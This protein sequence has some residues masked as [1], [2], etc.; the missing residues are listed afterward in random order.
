MK[1]S[2]PFIGV[3]LL[4]LSC[5]AYAQAQTETVSPKVVR[6]TQGAQGCD[7]VYK[8]GVGFYVLKHDGIIIYLTMQGEGKYLSPFLQVFNGSMKRFTVDPQSF[9]LYVPKTHPEL[10]ASLD[11]YTVAKSVG[12]RGRLR[13]ALAAGL[14]GAAT[15][16]ST[17]T[18][19]DNQGNRATVTATEPDTDAQERTRQAVQD[20]AEAN[21]SEAQRILQTS[22]KTNTLSQGEIATGFIYFN[23][24]KYPEFVLRFPIGDTVYEFP[25]V[26]AP[27]SKS[28]KQ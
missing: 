15:T 12:N 20:N 19:R 5:A 3:L 14:A 2:K 6:W 18:V 9:T 22:F 4:L 25:F 27:Q 10:I 21:L 8:E 13:G 23:N 16:Q 7:L 1:L 17:A 24:K 26:K 11:P 28:R